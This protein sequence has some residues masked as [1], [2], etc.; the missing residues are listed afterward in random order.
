MTTKIEDVEFEIIDG[1]N[2]WNTVLESLIK[3]EEFPF[4][5]SFQ[6]KHPVTGALL[7]G[8][9]QT[10]K[11]IIIGLHQALYDREK[12]YPN[13]W[14]IFGVCEKGSKNIQK[15][16]ALVN[17]KVSLPDYPIFF[18]GNYNTHLRRGKI[19]F[20]LPNVSNATAV[21]LPYYISKAL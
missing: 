4:V 13:S 9:V 2:R 20:I 14:F 19:R 17:F 21:I 6:T 8:H 15:G 7:E 16:L 12:N 10:L 5:V 1:P 3:K 11:F 18:T